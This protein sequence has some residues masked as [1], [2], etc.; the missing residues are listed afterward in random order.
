MLPAHWLT[1]SCGI[2]NRICRALDISVSDPTV[3]FH[4]D[5]LNSRSDKPI[6]LRVNALLVLLFRHGTKSS[7]AQEERL[8]TSPLLVT[9]LHLPYTIIVRLHA[10]LVGIVTFTPETAGSSGI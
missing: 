1:Y 6:S 5:L 4:V 9:R 2:F 10:H 8:A 7:I 3:N